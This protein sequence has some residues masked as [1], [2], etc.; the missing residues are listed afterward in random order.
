MLNLFENVIG[1]SFLRHTVYIILKVVAA[2]Y[3]TMIMSYSVAASEY[4]KAVSLHVFD[5]ITDEDS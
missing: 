4:D 3:R 5:S 1:S 2:N